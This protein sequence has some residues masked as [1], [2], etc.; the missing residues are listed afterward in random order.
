MRIFKSALRIFLTDLATLNRQ[1]TN[2]QNKR[3]RKEKQKKEIRKRR[4][5]NRIF[6]IFRDKIANYL[7]DRYVITTIRVIK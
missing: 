2:K 5:I 6:D 1:L 7:C 3:S 4:E